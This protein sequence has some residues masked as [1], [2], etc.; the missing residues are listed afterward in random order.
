MNVNRL[1]TE[2]RVKRNVIIVGSSSM[3]GGISTKEKRFNKR[4]CCFFV[5]LSHFA[6]AVVVCYCSFPLLLVIPV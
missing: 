6:I 4:C 3:F 5:C 1:K 2:S